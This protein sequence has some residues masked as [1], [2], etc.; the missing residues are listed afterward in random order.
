MIWLTWRQF[1]VQALAVAAVLVVAA[2]GLL[3]TTPDLIPG[4]NVFDQLTPTDRTVF[5][6]GMVVL[7]VAPA[8]LGAFWGAPLVAREL[9][10]GT[11]R[12]AWAQSVTRGR[13]LATK[14]GLTALAAAAAVGVLSLA[15]T[16]WADPI[17]GATSETTGSLPGRMTPVTFAM[18][19]VVPL[20]YGVFAL[21]LGVT[22]GLLLRRTLAAMAVTLVLYTLVQVAVPLWVRPHLA[23]P[24]RQTVAISLDTLDGIGYREGNPPKV[25][26]TVRT[27]APGSWVLENR[28]VDAAGRVL[29]TLPAS[30]ADCLPPPGPPRSAGPDDPD[31]VGGIE[32]CLRR[33]S[34]LGYRQ[35]VVYQPAS[36]FWRLQWTETGLYLVLS[37]LLAGLCFWRLRRLG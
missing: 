18:R 26:L 5:F 30:F 3:A 8:V 33:L 34:D 28:T 37:G 1:R 27:G 10:A 7:A 17:D 12:L 20:A 9:E 2:A 24:T 21:V 35:Q 23:P 16:W 29:T 19:G 11:H 36:R 32:S 15:V 6:T 22:A 25:Q 4:A 14:L 31:E 13:W